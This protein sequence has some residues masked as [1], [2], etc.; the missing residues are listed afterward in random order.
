M[1]EASGLTS[2]RV[3]VVLGRHSSY[4]STMLRRGSRPSGD[5][6]AR[7]AAACGYRL[8]LVP[9]DGSGPVLVVDGV[10]DD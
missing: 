6:L 2:Y 8:E 10:P 9:V 1:L 4:V 5:L 7:V 3:S